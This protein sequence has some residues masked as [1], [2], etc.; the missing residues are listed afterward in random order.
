MLKFSRKPQNENLQK[1]RPA[2]HEGDENDNTQGNNRMIT[3]ENQELID[4][5]KPIH[6]SKIK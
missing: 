6:K 2:N 1:S 3:V 4:V 5:T